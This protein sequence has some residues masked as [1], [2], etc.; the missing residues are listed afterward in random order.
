MA[1][2]PRQTV[3]Q[4]VFRYRPEEES[5]P[6]FERYE[7]PFRR[8]WVVLDALIYIKD[9][10]FTEKNTQD[11]ID[12]GAVPVVKGIESKLEFSPEKAA[13]LNAANLS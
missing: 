6:T 2:D 8:H 3:T 9:G 4:E 5:E 1:T 13:A 11:L 10:M 12:S 7:V